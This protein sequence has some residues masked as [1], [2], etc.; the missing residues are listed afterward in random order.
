[1]ASVIETS[2]RAL[3]DL[4]RDEPLGISELVAAMGV[5][6]TAVRQRLARLMGQGLIERRELRASRG[7][8]SHQY[9]LTER[10]QRQMGSNFADLALALW[11]EIRKIREPEVRNGLMGR[12]AQTLATKYAPQ[13]HGVTA[14]E[15]MTSIARL[16]ADRDVPFNVT[17]VDS[18]PVLTAQACP[19]PQLA[20]QDRGICSVEKMLFSQLVGENVRLSDCRLD[21]AT[22]CTFEVKAPAA[23][24]AAS[25]T[26]MLELTG[27][28]HSTAATMAEH[29]NGVPSNRKQLD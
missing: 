8:P 22:C 20:Q 21:G 10:G 9:Q 5:T 18:L 13:I 14:A 17:T 16:L 26:D 12:V 28:T 7:R 25:A 15:R 29:D 11:D 4:V 24:N 3:L 27:M 23:T 1:M 6:A 19:Y 2:D